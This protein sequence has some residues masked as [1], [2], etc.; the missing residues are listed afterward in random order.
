V[1]MDLAELLQEV[2]VQAF[3]S[4]GSLRDESRLKSWLTGIAV[5]TARKHIHKNARWFLLSKNHPE[6]EWP[7]TDASYEDREALRYTYAILERMPA[8]E[9]IA[10]SL[11][12]IEEM[13]LAE[14]AEACQVSLATIKRRL[15]KA[16]RRFLMLAVKCPILYEWIERGSRWEVTL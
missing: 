1:D 6:V 16:R 5:N 7:V 10:F 14:T 15:A 9:R 4:A 3:S 2:F 12:F 11:R 8:N 13:N